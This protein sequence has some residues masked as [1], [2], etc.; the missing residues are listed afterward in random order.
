[1]GYKEDIKIDKFALDEEWLRLA[2]KYVEWGEKEADALEE[3]E[4]AE[5]NLELVKG[6]IDKKIRFDPAFYGLKD[7]KEKAVEALIPQQAEYKEAFERLLQAKKHARVMTIAKKAFNRVARALDRLTDL[8]EDGY[9][10]DK[11]SEKRMDKAAEHLANK[12][13][14]E[15]MKARRKL[16]RREETNG[17]PDIS[18]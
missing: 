11:P 10:A 1:M 5:A 14:Q 2:G 7:I 15:D 13:F 8:Y 12:K 6:E 9:W 16:R 18:D 17:K 4:R 3:Q